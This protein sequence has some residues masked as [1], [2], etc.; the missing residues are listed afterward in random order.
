MIAD[1]L[2]RAERVHAGAVVADIR[3]SLT[4][5]DIHAVVPV[6]C[7]REPTVADALETALQ[8][9]AGAIVANSWPL[10]A[11][12]DVDAVSLTQPQFVSGRAN[13]FEVT[14]LIY[15][16]CVSTARIRNLERE[17]NKQTLR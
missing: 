4:L 11:L 13:A 7:E 1:A 5:V 10:V 2:V 6:P 3:I 16:L 17:L 9:V 12:V 14:L 8:V 15:A